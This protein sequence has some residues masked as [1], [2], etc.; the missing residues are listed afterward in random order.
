VLIIVRCLY[1]VHEMNTYRAG[2]VYQSACFDS[3]VAGWISMESVM[4]VP[5]I[6][7]TNM[8]EARTSEFRTHYLHIIYDPEIMYIDT[9][10]K[11]MHL[12]LRYLLL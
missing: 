3:I 4:A 11:N 10:L 6:N 9:S 12:W 2:R 8:T 1:D 5:T 7:N